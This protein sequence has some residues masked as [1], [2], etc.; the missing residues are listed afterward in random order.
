[1]QQ[2][3]K[4]SLLYST[5]GDMKKGSLGPPKAASPAVSSASWSL[6]SSLQ[7][8]VQESQEMRLTTMY[9]PFC[10][11]MMIQLNVQP[12]TIC[13]KTTGCGVEEEA[14]LRSVSRREHCWAWLLIPSGIF[15]VSFG[16]C[17]AWLW[18]LQIFEYSD[19]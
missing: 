7:L 2:A 1:M 16:N 10:P 15:V 8:D 3:H 17:I 13:T 6:H 4:A 14:E 18:I 11:S 5:E 19:P 12:H 9:S